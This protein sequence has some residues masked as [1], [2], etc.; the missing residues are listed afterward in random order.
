[1]FFCNDLKLWKINDLKML[2]FYEMI[3]EIR[4]MNQFKLIKNLVRNKI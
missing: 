2:V 3:S 1:M 4:K